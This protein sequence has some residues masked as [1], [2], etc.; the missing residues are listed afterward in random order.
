[1]KIGG[2]FSKPTIG[3]DA[4]SLVRSGLQNTLQNVLNKD[5]TQNGDAAAEENPEAVEE[6]LIRE[7]LGALFGRK[8]QPAEEEPKE[9][10]PQQ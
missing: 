6:T 8:K 10:D 4:E 9:E 7:G 3:I 1:M 5:K 2:T